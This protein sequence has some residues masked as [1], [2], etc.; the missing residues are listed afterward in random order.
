MIRLAPLFLMMILTPSLKGG[1]WP[2]FLGPQRDGS[3]PDESIVASISAG[4]RPIHW[5]TPA[6]EG[7]S[8]PVVV[9]G[10][11][12]LFHQPDQKRFWNRSTPS[13]ASRAGSSPTRPT[14]RGDTERGPARARRL[15]S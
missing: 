7:F 13:R 3:A 11:A 6:G 9:G 2:Q 4:N 10:A 5:R 1:D 12:Y 15:L 8:G 14:M